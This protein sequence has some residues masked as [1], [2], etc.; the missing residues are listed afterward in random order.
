[1]WSFVWQLLKAVATPSVVPSRYHSKVALL[2]SMF[3]FFPQLVDPIFH[4][5]WWHHLPFLTLR[6]ASIVVQ[7]PSVCFRQA[8]R[9]LVLSLCQTLSLVLTWGQFCLHPYSPE[10]FGD[11]ESHLGCYNL[12]GSG[13]E[14]RVLLVSSKQRPGMLLNVL[15]CT[16]QP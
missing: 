9:M 5:C 14:W 2:I 6:L 12:A 4:S 16:G 3:F 13:V 8:L 7:V 15:Q 1:M 10:A 11:I